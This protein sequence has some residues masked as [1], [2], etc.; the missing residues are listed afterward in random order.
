MPMTTPT[1]PAVAVSA[2][3]YALRKARAL[4]GWLPV[5][6]GA[7]WMA[8]RQVHQPPTDAQRA[9]CQRAR[10]AVTQRSPHLDQNGIFTPLPGEI[11]PHIEELRPPRFSVNDLNGRLIT[12]QER[13]QLGCGFE[14]ADDWSDAD[15]LPGAGGAERVA[16]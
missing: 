9:R 14:F 1:Q 7:L 13:R 10:D 8:G 5:E 11:L 3:G 16:G 6:E 4:I 2:P 12:L 15:W